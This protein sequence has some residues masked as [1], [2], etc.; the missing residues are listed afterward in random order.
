MLLHRSFE[1]DNLFKSPVTAK[2]TGPFSEDQ[3]GDL[4]E[5]VLIR[6]LHMPICPRC[7]LDTYVCTT[8]NVYIEDHCSTS[9]DSSVLL[10][11]SIGPEAIRAQISRHLSL[12]PALATTTSA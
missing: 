12:R 4:A 7:M 2:A 1:S 9:S 10:S 3:F 11:L 5:R 8:Y 6:I